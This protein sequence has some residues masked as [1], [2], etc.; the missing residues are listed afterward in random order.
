MG[1][2]LE[3]THKIVHRHLHVHTESQHWELKVGPK[4]L[5]ILSSERKEGRRQGEERWREV[6]REREEK[7]EK[8]K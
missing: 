4:G 1:E 3:N 5:E 8:R 7:R 6:T 2:G